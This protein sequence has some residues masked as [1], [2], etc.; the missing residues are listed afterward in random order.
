MRLRQFLNSVG[1]S[2]GHEY[3]PH[4]HSLD[5]RCDCERCR[6]QMCRSCISHDAQWGDVCGLCCDELKKQH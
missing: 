2:I 5:A 4:C 3:C 1:S 6:R